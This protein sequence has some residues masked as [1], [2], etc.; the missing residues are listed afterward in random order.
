MESDLEKR[1][2]ELR[3]LSP[4]PTA[5]IDYIAVGKLDHQMLSYIIASQ[6]NVFT[7]SKQGIF[8]I[9]FITILMRNTH[10]FTI[11]LAT[12]LKL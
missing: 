8:T 12:L 6:S 7:S 3:N 1:D 2:H 10:I 4:F 11:L 5:N 9:S